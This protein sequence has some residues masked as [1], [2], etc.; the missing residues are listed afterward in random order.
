[1]MS[2]VL[3]QTDDSP[4]PNP[5]IARLRATLTEWRR[6]QACAPTGRRKDMW[7]RLCAGIEGALWELGE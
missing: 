4:E 2:V 6:Y 1:M 5:E 7:T 3:V